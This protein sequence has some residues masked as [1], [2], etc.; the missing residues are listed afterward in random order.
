MKRTSPPGRTRRP[1]PPWSFERLEDRTLLSNGT[2]G[3][4]PGARTLAIGQDGA[5]TATGTL[6]SIGQVATY[7]FLAPASGLYAVE[8]IA[9]AGSNLD[10]SVTVSDNQGNLLASDTGDGPGQGVGA[11]MDSLVRVNMVGG[12]TYLIGAG[13]D[14]GNTNSIGAYAVRVS[15]YRLATPLIAGT[16]VQGTVSQD[17]MIDNYQFVPD[18]SGLYAVAEGAT[19]DS[20]LSPVVT[21]VDAQGNVLGSD[22]TTTDNTPDLSFDAT[23]TVELLAHHNYYIEAEGAYGDD[24]GGINVSVTPFAA[25]IPAT[26]QQ[27]VATL[28]GD[29]AQSGS[30]GLFQFQAPASGLVAVRRVAASDDPLTSY[31][32]VF[33][34]RGAPVALDDTSDGTDSLARFTATAGQTYYVQALLTTTQTSGSYTFQV[35]P[36]DFGDYTSEAFNIPLVGNQVATQSGTIEVSSL[37]TDQSG[38]S[39]VSGDTDVFQFVA[40]QTGPLVVRVDPGP[41]SEL[42]PSLSVQN[43]QGKT[44]TSAFGGSE[45]SVNQIVIQAK[46]GQTYYALVTSTMTAPEPTSCP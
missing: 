35:S 31:L 41:S 39:E 22:N 30:L 5:A 38:N 4:P 23:V 27:G 42:N 20:T 1:R 12:Q 19:S 9:P 28:T 40:S 15:P 17:G 7:T 45:D 6:T 2:I 36:D 37:V 8:E 25:A 24:T 10:T 34:G 46:A 29:V 18:I 32:T 11:M 14:L 33:D 21:V 3:V 44:P 43:S 13:G 26:F 16:T